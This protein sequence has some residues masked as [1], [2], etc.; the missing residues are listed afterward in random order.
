MGSGGARNVASWSDEPAG[1]TRAA[2]A[3]TYDAGRAG[4]WQCVGRAATADTDLGC[5]RDADSSECG[6]GRTNGRGARAS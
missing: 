3:S 6:G 4:W 1:W 5:G 2:A